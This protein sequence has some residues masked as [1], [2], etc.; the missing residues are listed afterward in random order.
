MAV[1]EITVEDALTE[2]QRTHEEA[3]A[4]MKHVAESLN[5]PMPAMVETVSSSEGKV[6]V[7][8]EQR[9]DESLSVATEGSGSCAGFP[10]SFQTSDTCCGGL[11]CPHANG[12]CCGSATHC[13]PQ[14]YVCVKGESGAQCARHMSAI[15]P[16]PVAEPAKASSI[17]AVPTSG[18]PAAPA[19]TAQTAPAQPKEAPIEADEVKR[20]GCDGQASCNPN[21]IIQMVEPEIKETS[22]SALMHPVATKAKK[23]D[24]PKPIQ[25]VQQDANWV[26]IARSSG[27]NNMVAWTTGS[28]NN[29]SADFIDACTKYNKLGLGESVIVRLTMG[30]VVDYFRPTKNKNLC[31][32][33]TSHNSHAW[34]PSLNGPWRVPDYIRS[35]KYT[36]GGSIDFWL[37]RITYGKDPRKYVSFWGSVDS[38]G[39][40]CTSSYRASPTSWGQPYVLHLYVGAPTKEAANGF[41]DY[42]RD[43]ELLSQPAK[44]KLDELEKAQNEL[45]TTTQKMAAEAQNSVKGVMSQV[46]KV[47]SEIKELETLQKLAEQTRNEAAIIS[48]EDKLADIRAKLKTIRVDQER[49]QKDVAQRDAQEQTEKKNEKVD[50]ESRKKSESS[51]KHAEKEQRKKDAEELVKQKDQEF[52]KVQKE[53]E[54]QRDAALSKAADA[55]EA[56]IKA[57]DEADRLASDRDRLEQDAASQV[58]KAKEEGQKIAQAKLETTKEAGEKDRLKRLQKLQDE[59]AEEQ[60]KLTDKLSNKEEDNKSNTDKK[61]RELQSKIEAER[62]AADATTKLAQQASLLAQQAAQQ[63]ETA[64]TTATTQALQATTAWKNRPQVTMVQQVSVSGGPG[65]ISMGAL[66]AAAGDEASQKAVAAAGSSVNL[67]K[68]QA[69]RLAADRRAKQE[70]LAAAQAAAEVDETA[71]EEARKAEESF[72]ES[73]QKSTTAAEQAQ[74]AKSSADKAAKDAAD[75]AEADAQEQSAKKA[76]SNEKVRVKNAEKDQKQ[77]AQTKNEQQVKAES[78]AKKR[79]SARQAEELK[80]KKLAQEQDV[81]TKEA[82]EEATKA[83]E[84]EALSRE[85]DTKKEKAASDAREL[86]NKAAELV[87]ESEQKSSEAKQKAT[88]DP[89]K[90]TNADKLAAEAAEAASKAAQRQKDLIKAQQV[91]ESANKAENVAESSAKKTQQDEQNSKAQEGT[92]KGQGEKDVKAVAEASIK[93]EQLAKSNSKE[94]MNK[95]AEKAKAD[96]EA[97]K[98]S[99]AAFED[100][101]K[102]FQKQA[103]EGR[104]KADNSEQGAKTAAGKA[105]EDAKKFGRDKTNNQ[106]EQAAKASANEAKQKIAA[107]EA[108]GKTAEVKEKKAM[109]AEQEV[110]DA[111][112]KGKQ[113]RLEEADSKKESGFKAQ[114]R[115]SEEKANSLAK[116]Q[117]EKNGEVAQK[118]A[119][120][121]Q[122]LKEADQKQAQAEQS[123]KKLQ[124]EKAT[125]ELNK[126]EADAKKAN[127]VAENTEKAKEQGTKKEAAEKKAATEVSE[128]ADSQRRA[129]QTTKEQ[130]EKQQERF[131]KDSSEKSNKDEQTFKKNDAEKKKEQNEKT[132]AVEAEK[133]REMERKKATSEIDAKTEQNVKTSAA[134]AS[135]KTTANEGSAKANFAAQEKKLKAQEEAIKADQEKAAEEQAKAL[136]N[137]DQAAIERANRNEETVKKHEADYKE[138]ARNQERAVKSEATSKKTAAEAAV[139]KN[140]NAILEQ[141]SKEER[142]KQDEMGAKIEQNAQ[143]ELSNKN[144]QNTKS[145]NARAAEQNKKAQEAQENQAKSSM[146]EQQRKQE[147]A[148]KATVKENEEKAARQANATKATQ[149]ELEA[150]SNAKEAKV[151]Q[152]SQNANELKQKASASSDDELQRRSAKAAAEAKAQLQAFQELSTKLEVSNKDEAKTKSDL[153]NQSAKDEAGIKNEQKEKDAVS[154]SVENSAKSEQADK[155]EQEVKQ[156]ARQKDALR[157]PLPPRPTLSRTVFSVFS[158]WVSVSTDEFGDPSFASVGSLCFLSGFVRLISSSASITASITQLPPECRPSERNTFFVPNAGRVDVFPNGDVKWIEGDNKAQNLSLSSISFSTQ[159]RASR[160]ALQLAP[161][162][163]AF[164]E[165]YATPSYTRQIAFQPAN[166][167]RVCWGANAGSSTKFEINGRGREISA[168]RV[169]WVSGGFRCA[170]D[171]KD[172]YW[173]CSDSFSTFFTLKSENDRIIYPLGKEEG[174][175]FVPNSKTNYRLDSRAPDAP[176]VSFTLSQP[177]PTSA[178]GTTVFGIYHGRDIQ[179]VEGAGPTG[180]VCANVFVRFADALCSLTGTIKVDKIDTI[181]QKV[182]SEPKLLATLPADCAPEARISAMAISGEQPVRID[183]EPNGR[184]TLAPR[185]AVRPSQTWVSLSGISFFGRS[186]GLTLT[187]NSGFSSF[188]NSWRAASFKRQGRMCLLSGALKGGEA[189][190]NALVRVGGPLPEYCRPPRT[191]VFSTRVWNYSSDAKVAPVFEFHTTH[192]TSDGLVFMK[193]Y[194]PDELRS[195]DGIRFYVDDAAVREN[196]GKAKALADQQQVDQQ[197]AARRA[198]EEA[199]RMREEQAGKKE[200]DEKNAKQQAEL[201]ASENRAKQEA[202]TKSAKAAEEQKKQQDKLAEETTKS[203]AAEQVAKSESKE[204]S[205]KAKEQTARDEAAFNTVS[206]AQPKTALLKVSPTNLLA[207]PPFSPLRASILDKTCFLGGRVIRTD[208]DVD[209]FA[210]LP[211]GCVP[212]K[213]QL[214]L[215]IVSGGRSGLISAAPNGG[216]SYYGPATSSVSVDGVIVNL[217]NSSSLSPL[218]GYTPAGT[219]FQNPAYSR[220]ADVCVLSGVLAISTNKPF[221]TQIFTLPTECRPMDGN[222]NF[223][224]AL[225]DKDDLESVY[226]QRIEIT[227]AGQV[228]FQNTAAPAGFKLLS[229]HGI[230]FPVGFGSTMYSPPQEKLEYAPQVPPPLQKP[231]FVEENAEE[232]EEAVSFLETDVEIETHD[233]SVRADHNG[234]SHNPSAKKVSQ[235]AAKR[236]SD[237]HRFANQV[238]AAAASTAKVVRA[239]NIRP[240]FHVSAAWT[241]SSDSSRGASFYRVG[242]VCMLSGSIVPKT[243]GDDK[244]VRLLGNLP[245]VC[246]PLAGTQSFSISRTSSGVNVL[247]KVDIDEAGNVIWSESSS[248]FRKAPLFLDGIVFI[249]DNAFTQADSARR[250]AEVQK[251]NN[252][253]NVPKSAPLELAGGV[254]KLDL[255]YGIPSVTRTGHVCALSGVVYTGLRVGPIATLPEDCRPNTTLVMYALASGG[256]ISSAVTAPRTTT[257][258]ANV[259]PVPATIARDVKRGDPAWQV[260]GVDDLR[261]LSALN[262]SFPFSQSSWTFATDRDLFVQFDLDC[263]NDALL[264]LSAAPAAL[265]S[266]NVYPERFG[267]PAA[268]DV[269]QFTRYVI[270]LGAAN[271]TAAVIRKKVAGGTPTDAATVKG[272]YCTPGVPSTYWVRYT[273]NTIS[274]GKGKK[275]GD[276]PFLQFTEVAAD[277]TSLYHF[278]FS[279]VDKP[280]I[281]R[282]IIFGV[283]AA[284]ANSSMIPIPDNDASL[285]TLGTTSQYAVSRGANQPYK[286]SNLN[287]KEWTVGTENDLWITLRVDCQQEALIAL[288]PPVSTALNAANTDAYE[289]VLGGLSNTQWALRTR[290]ANASSNVATANYRACI[291]NTR[292][293]VWVSIRG[294]VITAGRGRKVGAETLLSYTAPDPLPTARF[295]LG[296]GSNKASFYSISWGVRKGTRL[297]TRTGSLARYAVGVRN[298]KYAFNT[299]RFAVSKERDLWLVA[300]V[301]CPQ[302]LG[303]L[304]ALSSDR[305]A[306]KDPANDGTNVYEILVSGASGKNSI[307]NGAQSTRDLAT[308]NNNICANGKASF[309][310]RYFQDTITF[311][312]GREVG[313]NQLLTWS[314]P[315]TRS[316]YFFDLS[317]SADALTYTYL[318]WGTS[319][320]FTSFVPAGSLES[321]DIATGQLGKYAFNQASRFRSPK[322]DDVWVSFEADCTSELHFTFSNVNKLATAP[323]ADTEQRYEIVYGALQNTRILG[324]KKL[325]GSEVATVI[326]SACEPGRFV[327]LWARYLRGVLS[328]GRGSEVGKKAFFSWT[329][330]APKQINFFDFASNTTEIQLQNLMWGSTRS[331]DSI[332]APVSFLETSAEFFPVEED[333]FPFA[334]DFMGYESAV[335]EAEE[336]VSPVLTASLLEVEQIAAVPASRPVRLTIDPNGVISQGL[337]PNGKAEWLSLSGIAFIPKGDASYVFQ[338]IPLENGWQSPAED[339]NPSFFLESSVCLLSGAVK[340]LDLAQSQRIIGKLPMECT[341]R[342]SLTFQ[343]THVDITVQLEVRESGDIVWTG[344]ELLPEHFSISLDRI[345]FYV[346]PS[347]PGSAAAPSGTSNP[348]PVPN[349]LSLQSGWNTRSGFS[350]PFF[351]KIGSLCV[352]SGFAQGKGRNVIATLPTDCR[353]PFS[354]VFAARRLNGTVRIDV[355]PNG[356]IVQTTDVEGW[357]SLDGVAFFMD[358]TLIDQSVELSTKTIDRLRVERPVS[359]ELRYLNNIRAYGEGFIVPSFSVVDGLCFISGVASTMAYPGWGNSMIALLPASC[360]PAAREAFPGHYDPGNGR[361]ITRY[362][363]H[364]T[365]FVEIVNSVPSVWQGLSPI[366]FVTSAAAELQFSLPLNAPWKNV[367][368]QYGDLS[369]HRSGAWCTISG[370][371]AVGRTEDVAKN[372]VISRLPNECRPAGR[373][374]FLVSQHDS[375][376]RVDVL[377]DGSIVWVTGKVNAPWLSLS[378]VAFFSD[379]SPTLSSAF[380]QRSLALNPAYRALGDLYR[381]PSFRRQGS[382]CA[383]SGVA[384]GKGSLIG[385]LPAECRPTG[386]RGM[387]RVNRDSETERIDIAPDGSVQWVSASVNAATEAWISLDGI[388][389]VIDESFAS[390]VAATIRSEYEGAG[391][392]K[393]SAAE[394]AVSADYPAYGHPYTS[395]RFTRFG[396]LCSLSGALTIVKQAPVIIT[397]PANCRPGAK[398]IFGIASRDDS[399]ARVEVDPQGAV[400]LVGGNFT[401][402]VPLDGIR[403]PVAGTALNR[404]ALYES[405]GW[406][407]Y[408]NG[409]QSASWLRVGD[410]CHFFGVIT[411]VDKTFSP[412]MAGVPMECRPRDGRIIFSA[413]ASNSA[414]RLLTHR[415]DHHNLGLLLWANGDTTAEYLSLSGISNFA[416]APNALALSL[417]TPFTVFNDGYRPPQLAKQG[418]LCVVSGLVNGGSASDLRRVV[419]NIPPSTGCLPARRLSFT[420]NHDGA[421]ERVEFWPDGSIRWVDGTLNG[422]LSLDGIQLLTDPVFDAREAQASTADLQKLSTVQPVSTPLN[423]SAGV[424]ASATEAAPAV[425][426][427]D[428]VCF[429]SGTFELLSDGSEQQVATLQAPCRP[430]N[431]LV[432]TVAAAGAGAVRVDIIP[433]GAVFINRMAK[434]PVATSI[435]LDGIHFTPS[436]PRPI[437]LNAGYR[438]GAPEW[439]TPGVYRY[440]E[441]CFLVGQVAFD[442]NNPKLNTTIGRLPP[443][444]RPDDAVLLTIGNIGTG[445]IRLEVFNTGQLIRLQNSLPATATTINL[446]NVGFFVGSAGKPLELLNGFSHYDPIYRTPSYRKQGALCALSGLVKSSNDQSIIAVLPAECRPFSRLTFASTRENNVAAIHVLPSGQVQVSARDRPSVSV[447]Y[448]SLDGIAF[449]VDRPLFDQQSGILTNLTNAI[450]NEVAEAL[451]TKPTI[452]SMSMG[453]SHAAFGASNVVETS[454][455]ASIGWLK[456]APNVAPWPV[457]YQS[458]RFTRFGDFCIVSG[459]VRRSTSYGQIAYLPPD[460]RPDAR[461]IYFSITDGPVPERYDVYPTGVVKH[462]AGGQITGSR[463]G[464]LSGI[465]FAVS[466]AEQKNIPL[467][468]PAWTAW[469]GDY[470]A[471]RWSRSGNLCVLSGVARIENHDMWNSLIG[472]LPAECRPKGRLIFASS[473][474]EFLSVSRIDIFPD[475]RITHV[476]NPGRHLWVSFANIA[477]MVSDAKPILQLQNGWAPY[478]DFYGPGYHKEG[479][480]C[481]LTGALRFSSTQATRLVA[482]L[483]AEC[484]PAFGGRLVFPTNSHQNPHR[485]DITKDGEIVFSE[486]A[487]ITNFDWISLEGIR[488]VARLAK[489]NEVRQTTPLTLTAPARA[490][491]QEYAFPEQHVFDQVCYLSGLLNVDPSKKQKQL[492]NLDRDCQIPSQLVLLGAANGARVRLD[493]LNNGQINNDSP[494]NSD[495]ISLGFAKYPT[496]DAAVKPL[497][498]APQWSN[499][500]DPWSKPSYFKSGDLCILQGIIKPGNSN[501]PSLITTLPAECFPR[502]GALVF[503]TLSNT[504]GIRL[505]VSADG[506]V[507]LAWGKVDNFVSLDNIAFIAQDGGQVLSLGNGF[508]VRSG[509]RP[510]QWRRQGA[511]C[512]LTGS[513]EHPST[514]ADTLLTTLPTDCR[515][516]DRHVFNVFNQDVGNRVDVFPDGRV[517][518]INP[519]NNF[520]NS[521][522]TL[523][524]IAFFVPQLRSTTALPSAEYLGPQYA[525]LDNL[526]LLSGLVASSVKNGA[527]ASLPADCRPQNRLIFSSVTEANN[528]AGIA[529]L[530]VDY[531]PESGLSIVTDNAVTGSAGW[532]TLSN[533][534]FPTAGTK[535]NSLP[536]GSAWAPMASA[537]QT[538]GYYRYGRL[539][540]LT[541]AANVKDAKLWSE[542]NPITLLPNDCRPEARLTFHTTA[543]PGNSVRLDVFPNGQVLVRSAMKG[544]TWVSLSNI[545]FITAGATATPVAL[546]SNWQASG[547]STRAPS[548]STFGDIC[549]LTGRVRATNLIKD[550]SFEEVTLPATNWQYMTDTKTGWA[551]STGAGVAKVPSSWGIENDEVPDGKN[552][553]LLQS[554]AAH[555]R[556]TVAGP[557]RTGKYVLSYSVA[558][559]SGHDS[560]KQP[561]GLRVEFGGVQIDNIAP[562][563]ITSSWERRHITFEMNNVQANN[564]VLAFLNNF[565]V[566]ADLTVFIDAVTLNSVS[567]TDEQRAIGRLPGQCTPSSRLVFSTSHDGAEMRIDVHPNGVVSVAQGLPSAMWLSLDGIRFPVSPMGPLRIAANKGTVG[568]FFSSGN[569]AR[570]TSFAPEAFASSSANGRPASRLIDGTYGDQ[571]AWQPASASGSIFAGVRFNKEVTVNTIAFGAD[572]S[573]VEA[574]NVPIPVAYTLQYSVDALDASASA[575]QWTTIGRVA[576]TTLTE[577][578]RRHAFVLSRPVHAKSIRVLCEGNCQIDE[579]EVYPFA[580]IGMAVTNVTGGN[581]L[582]GNLLTRPGVVTFSSSELSTVW[583]TRNANNGKYGDRESWIPDFNKAAPNAVHYVGFTMEKESD[584]ASIAIGRDNTG[585]LR[586]R[587]DGHW[588]VQYTTQAA[589][590]NTPD[591]A[592]TTIGATP[593]VHDMK[594]PALRHVFWFDSTVKAR[595]VRVILTRREMCIDEVELYSTRV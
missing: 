259:N 16:A 328:A 325:A 518:W 59:A 6:E 191:V 534:I 342:T 355:N 562:G 345:F 295:D 456:L 46:D 337:N 533:V 388:F 151:K 132:Q 293:R 322:S 448:F 358:K 251:M 189:N 263:T 478:T 31:A 216:L 284:A 161:A 272:V 38:S 278:D 22:D 460:C 425:S 350:L 444:C 547:L 580:E 175:S 15:S 323:A 232:E 188:G 54:G 373:L 455:E 176:H 243:G 434:G 586:D 37:K 233:E 32:M 368:G 110:K 202:Q 86:A 530:R 588:I 192:I 299:T 370:V 193:G 387:Y 182:D 55:S 477:F 217:A 265:R 93:S 205:S 80:N 211:A 113:V 183:I 472:T 473:H 277:V 324:R 569:L 274:V 94:R 301:N 557:L 415:I 318:A 8:S 426:R 377:P 591:S 166:P 271:N 311:G 542:S 369:Y 394:L 221:P 64:A 3:E 528:P 53:L 98:K 261:S 288:Y 523:D 515:P 417:S 49:I 501:P 348:V 39:G 493:V 461:Q 412:W 505:D 360:R 481:F 146:S 253:L 228:H 103:L 115:E 126:K 209:T 532:W 240:A 247:E 589:N 84:A 332:P 48:V 127:Q 147:D 566:D 81:K 453:K 73:D 524:G 123:A 466:G 433:S 129:E 363:V 124:N 105:E 167:T 389:F 238:N 77:E 326:Y 540:V 47:K 450:N 452:F 135:Q 180:T 5:I 90:Q 83:V 174:L 267:K 256:P 506:K 438:N 420:V 29:A 214:Y 567:L 125:E 141:S 421:N 104:Q 405:N 143:Q 316:V 58:A 414:N 578:A 480:M 300:T 565:P 67:A 536:L 229:L 149:N 349:S 475:G 375:N 69:D 338:T 61:N 170:G 570:E 386:G 225:F 68:S 492:A 148:N 291:P 308:V 538:A 320:A 50:E 159:A 439:T 82:I 551:L 241:P 539:C 260:V 594:D 416:N 173:G 71:Q 464:T 114:T 246:R 491:G 554:K 449:V 239:S 550:W 109:K 401:G 36:G 198:A 172:S 593:H 119:V 314:S 152:D 313:S 168:I 512:V 254:R 289:F 196:I 359:Q 312:K 76:E 398:H 287:E 190:T 484:T 333:E 310:V 235:R 187:L 154:K 496:K 462:E 140:D 255:Q 556:Q 51:R 442:A 476:L 346:D 134:E 177:A 111:E 2:I 18:S 163:S 525:R 409:Y 335:M 397:L 526:C 561:V 70:R 290:T 108:E 583:N 485:I 576:S 504:N 340:A 522:F 503:N 164:S 315:T 10:T 571:N 282:D 33:L 552:Y 413:P 283:A 467:N 160:V 279:T 34:S 382:L 13:C 579:I 162:W 437:V 195:L 130:S 262:A 334:H 150:K 469:G 330:P 153:K 20:K 379:A 519:N 393:A 367:G 171:S 446:N 574:N 403:F 527:V 297:L 52:Q 309:W 575:T 459:L 558:R 535:I 43:A 128:K 510:P 156:E 28:G 27:T 489:P 381:V 281:F 537:F 199:I 546:T 249:V 516:A 121:E 213:H 327:R 181:S 374:I 513:L 179:R 362:D 463:Y 517:V 72:K 106:L 585:G 488:F 357:I 592:W 41:V 507:T 343:A 131:S 212:T 395:P 215:T 66:A 341:P 418:P 252:L 306:V 331:N 514:S 78:D 441:Y 396:A 553:L 184:V 294:G 296:A 245:S 223:H 378:G 185:S 138:M 157:A 12:V 92:T 479:D 445:S 454:H 432:F 4:A 572:N 234:L 406:D 371:V 508:A 44:Q 286:R 275:V 74:K 144:E 497:T 490:W 258:A 1:A 25:D 237:Q 407:S 273:N 568:G 244:L 226:A 207:L 178:N 384:I 88:K 372:P 270:N 494:P 220:V 419:A 302:T 266:Q 276:K 329:D 319:S 470:G 339:R 573:Y 545:A 422:W 250:T 17:L 14:G 292:Q 230:S 227:Q 380:T 136:K 451:N 560:Y 347:L 430:Q 431:Q 204:K 95:Q 447:Q 96:E 133:A 304:V 502:D 427:L 404:L 264:A 169:E 411:S 158:P 7:D 19:A 564:P 200:A 468:S 87:K 203:D 45:A 563:N 118:A 219:D 495:W 186:N 85:Q 30:G 11:K 307:R 544:E 269:D 543:S 408:Y 383:L 139:K 298:G 248:H 351:R 231:A 486:D 40:C 242:N 24:K 268:A 142:Q 595:S 399:L 457:N 356:E 89:S 344:G 218:N 458:P 117:S 549:V 531:I 21:D 194:R 101:Q 23:E 165:E 100:N 210:T 423:L 435:S 483:P 361:Q 391:V 509:A 352:I 424:Y 75:K 107:S 559:R 116:E 376:H 137:K 97:D 366:T 429:L 120:A 582:A 197:N 555:A 42:S 206:K 410:W 317:S 465:A 285:V 208:D 35:D 590:K 511:L 354:Q 57:K 99:A 112:V 122:R 482:R 353:P 587:I 224:V 440:G 145:A 60:Q 364:P 541:G 428:D 280:A 9:L 577:S 365:G 498:L 499:F 236:A 321:F 305:V 336:K 62:A 222:L 63:A 548:F 500:G 471:P 65:A 56:A 392:L 102:A 443:E 303:A 91:A 581:I 474:G 520:Q 529:D 385:T 79:E 390:Q 400:R 155:K 402:F 201:V 521:W 26:L 584:I 436:A 257:V 487:E